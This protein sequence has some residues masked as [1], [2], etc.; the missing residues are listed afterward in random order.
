MKKISIKDLHKVMLH[1]LKLLLNRKEMQNIDDMGKAARR[2]TWR[3][4]Y[5]Q[6]NQRNL[7]NVMIDYVYVRLSLFL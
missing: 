1:I 7:D 6:R 5:V 4:E 3:S 2:K